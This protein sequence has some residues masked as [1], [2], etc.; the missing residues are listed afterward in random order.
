MFFLGHGSASPFL[1]AIIIHG[2]KRFIHLRGELGLSQLVQVGHPEVAVL[3]AG[4]SVY[5][6]QPIYLWVPTIQGEEFYSVDVGDEG[7]IDG[8]THTTQHLAV[9]DEP[10]PHANCGPLRRHSVPMCARARR[11]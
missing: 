2:L 7:F 6:K 5:P 8:H 1:V 4:G 10:R 3:A 11:S 9:D